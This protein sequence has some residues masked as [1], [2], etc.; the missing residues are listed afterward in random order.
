MT[1]F[2]KFLSLVNP[3]PPNQ[4]PAPQDEQW[5]LLDR[6]R[7]THALIN[8]EHLRSSTTYQS[9][10]L[11]IDMDS[12]E[13]VIDELFPSATQKAQPGDSVQI[14]SQSQK[15]PIHFVTRILSRDVAN[16][17]PLWRL[18]L[19]D[20]IG[21]S[22]RRDAYRVY[23]AGEENLG[24][25]LGASNCDDDSKDTQ[26][27]DGMEIVNLSADGL[28]FGFPHEYTT[29]LT[30]HRQFD[31]CVLSLPNGH[32]IECIVTL[33]NVYHLNAP[34]AHGLANASLR[35]N[36]P[37]QRVQLDQFLAAVQRRQRRREQHLE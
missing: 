21:T 1:F 26:W 36:N 12:H 3:T 13:L 25:V 15:M 8:V 31:N 29:A 10:I 23:V 11:Q 19:P 30:I 32:D 2:R 14:S 6:L 28:K 4:S 37:Q 35:I 7:A 9:M 24:I 5:V 20:N 22:Y 18:E 33:R 16:G 17:T 27:F 34:H